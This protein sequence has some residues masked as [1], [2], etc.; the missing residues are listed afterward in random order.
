M[1]SKLEHTNLK[2]KAKGLHNRGGK[3]MSMVGFL[4]LA[5]L[6]STG[7]TIDVDRP[8]LPTLRCAQ[9][10][11]TGQGESIIRIDEEQG[12]IMAGLRRV[13]PEIL[14]RIAVTD[15]AGAAIL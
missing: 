3:A 1:T 12:L 7:L 2:K 10:V 6:A 5:T 11:I 9:A 8:L 4:L 14:Y 15:R 13:G